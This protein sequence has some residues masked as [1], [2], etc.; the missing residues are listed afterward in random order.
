MNS[1]AKPL[2]ISW[3]AVCLVAAGCGRSDS[4]LAVYI[5]G[6]TAGWITPCGCAANQS[7]GLARRSTLIQT[8]QSGVATLVLDAGGSASGTTDYH[9]LKLESILRGMQAMGLAAHNIGD[10]ESRLGP[11]ELRQLQQQTGVNWLS[12]NLNSRQGD[13]QPQKVITLQQAGLQ[14]AVVG[15]IDPS[16]VDDDLWQTTEPLQAVLR[17]LRDVQADVR[18]V[19]AYMKEPELRKLAAALP[20]VDFIV[21]GPTGQAVSPVT[22]GSVTVLSA[23]NKGKFLARLDLN[24]PDSSASVS[25]QASLVEVASSFDEDRNQV[26]NLADY[27]QRL[28]EQDFTAASAGLV[29]SFVGDRDDYAIAGSAACV[30]CHRQDDALWHA[31]RHSHA[32]DVLVVRGAHFDPFCQQCHTTGY[33]ITGGF[34]NV[35]QSPQRTD[36]GCENCHG[37]SQGHVDN[38]RV[39][40]PFNAKEQCIRC[41]DH[42]NSPDFV[43]DLYWS[44]ILHGKHPAQVNAAD[45]AAPTQNTSEF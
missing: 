25:K 31:S 28:A 38:P 13:W 6:D 37:P 21:G 39:K 42:E 3:A 29:S 5:S 33:G 11:A 36:V 30:A 7:G 20:E 27:Y 12:A 32:W 34:A 9:R 35:A 15:V 10:S 2:V 4:S 43:Q 40:T 44:K 22:V 41:H 1:C 18:I 26:D 16:G 24:R 19:L 17:A 23:T 8:A 45:G 14:I